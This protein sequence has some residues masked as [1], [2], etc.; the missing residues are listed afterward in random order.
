[1]RVSGE[2][3]GK[4]REGRQTLAWHKSEPISVISKPRV[5]A[6]EIARA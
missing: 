6:P 2:G 1:M 3:E 5:R 4:R